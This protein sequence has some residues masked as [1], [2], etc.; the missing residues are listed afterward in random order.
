MIWRD[1]EQVKDAS[2][3]LCAVVDIAAVYM[4]RRVLPAQE[5]RELSD[6]GDHV[7]W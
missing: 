2:A 5:D 3:R 4:Q 7:L 1:V 6:G